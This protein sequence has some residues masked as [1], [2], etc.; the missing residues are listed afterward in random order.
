MFHFV[1]LFCQ[2]RK[3]EMKKSINNTDMKSQQPVCQR[4]DTVDVNVEQPK[5]TYMV[6]N[7]LRDEYKESSVDLNNNFFKVLQSFVLV[8]SSDIQSPSW[9]F[10]VA[11]SISVNVSESQARHFRKT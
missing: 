8:F 10:G 6:F 9:S 3:N 11:Q 2:Y 4:G 7:S 5:Q 1:T